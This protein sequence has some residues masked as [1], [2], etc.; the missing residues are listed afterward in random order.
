[1][2]F[3]GDLLSQVPYRLLITVKGMKFRIVFWDVL[4][5]KIIVDR[6]RRENLKSHMFRGCIVQTIPCTA[7]I[8]SSFVHPHLSSNHP[9]S[10][11]GNL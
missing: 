6:R 7:A 1:V 9:D 4:P 3:V 8:F 10:S 11:A 5:C 2:K